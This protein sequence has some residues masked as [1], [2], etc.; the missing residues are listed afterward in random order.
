MI[1]TRTGGN[2][3]AAA[4]WPRRAAALLVGT[5]CLRGPAAVAPP[6]AEGACSGAES[7][8]RATRDSLDKGQWR[9]AERRLLALETSHPDCGDVA[10]GLARVRDFQGGDAEAERLFARALRLAPDDART[11]ALVAEHALSRGQLA[12]A[13]YESSLALSLEPECSEALVASGRLLG[14]Q[15]RLPESFRAMEKAA[16]VGPANPEAQYQL[17]VLLFRRKLHPDAVVQFRRAVALRPHDARAFDFLALCY[18]A[19]GDAERAERSY[20][21]ALETNEPRSPFFDFFLDHNYG[22]FL[23]KERRLSESQPHLDRAVAL[24]PNSRAAYYERGK[25]NLALERYPAAREDAERALSLRDEGGLVLDVQVHYLLA[26]VYA[27]LGEVDLARR[28]AELA[29]TT[30][31]P[32]RN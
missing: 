18:E 19:L 12:R 29:R 22:R 26:T 2:G 20:K 25:L 3:Q 13:D 21:A 23:L 6:N 14:I 7:A 17:G 27:R 16:R 15:G 10:L 31:I 11:H 32:D 28:H 1:S 8:L 4:R 5:W 24:L 9:N 30:P